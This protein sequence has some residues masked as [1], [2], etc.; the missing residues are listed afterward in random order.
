MRSG[1]SKSARLARARRGCRQPSARSVHVP[2]RPP[3]L[4]PSLSVPPPTH[5]CLRSHLPV[6][7]PALEAH[8][9]A[10]W[11]KAF[12]FGNRCQRLLHGPVRVRL[13]VKV[14]HKVGVGVHRR[15]PVDG[16]LLL[17]QPR[18]DAK[19]DLAA[20]TQAQH[21]VEGRLLLD[22]VVRQRAAVLQLLA[23]EDQALLVGRDPCVREA[24][25][26]ARWAHG[27]RRGGTG[28]RRAAPARQMPTVQVN[29]GVRAGVSVSA[30][31]DTKR[32][33]R[34]RAKWVS[35]WRVEPAPP[36]S[37]HAWLGGKRRATR[38]QLLDR[39]ATRAPRGRGE[40]CPPPPTPP[41]PA[42]RQTAAR[43]S[44]ST[45]PRAPSPSLSWILAL[46]LSMVS[47]DST[48][49]VMVLPVSVF[50]KICMTIGGGGGREA[51]G[52]GGRR[53]RAEWRALSRARRSAPA[54]GT[55]RGNGGT[56]PRRVFAFRAP[57]IRPSLR[58]RQRAESESLRG[59]SGTR[60]LSPGAGGSCFQFPAQD[61]ASRAN[62]S[63]PFG[64]IF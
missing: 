31:D 51:G 8:Q 7:V 22:V 60:G 6:F 43:A 34:A 53:P 57:A 49:S 38:S 21:E 17:L 30:P 36:H 61:R 52:G 62:A 48:S 46:T 40:A 14:A 54:G 9:A 26:R 64:D 41:H 25:I 16:E 47:E 1:V 13:K 50:T 24:A 27:R 59:N 10:H 4:S 39:R 11:V 3:A 23:G 37:P 32:R 15:L 44:P 18:L 12:D 42:L 2:H 56:A 55:T 45:L 58:L 28:E 5:I 63:M 29:H 35:G 33:A 19:V 20:A